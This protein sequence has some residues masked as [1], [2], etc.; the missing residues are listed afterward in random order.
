M[1]TTKIAREIL[2]CEVGSTA[3]GINL[4]GAADFDMMGVAV[5]TPD[6]ILSISPSFE[7][8]I[9]RTAEE[10]D[11]KNA[12]SKPGDTDI[13]IYSLRKFARLAARGNPSILL[14]LFAPIITADM[15]GLCLREH[16]EIF[17]SREAGQSFLGYLR[18][19]KERLLG[20]RGG[21][22]VTR[23]EI[24][25]KYGYDVKYAAHAIRLGYQGHELLSTGNMTVPI[26]EPMRSFL[27]RVRNGIF[28]L[29]VIVA[30]IEHWENQLLKDMKQAELPP[31]AHT[32]KIN[33]LLFRIH[34]E[35]WGY[36]G[37][38]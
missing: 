28:S 15:W 35:V 22:K 30:E 25:A 31:H 5:E 9:T 1:S 13:V 10:R 37:W 34:G 17:I 36:E 21:M 26:P 11:G 4:P 18:A 6:S 38:L 27:L 12:P 19:Q 24:V 29:R 14:L 2:R 33:D 32:E 3:L 16:K 7:Q 20:E 8:S 23:S